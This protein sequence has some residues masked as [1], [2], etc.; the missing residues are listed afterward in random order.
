MAYPDNKEMPVEIVTVKDEPEAHRMFINKNKFGKKNLTADELFCHEYWGNE[1]QGVETEKD[2]NS[3]FLS[4]DLGT[5]E[6]GT[7]V[8]SKEGFNVDHGVTVA[9]P[10]FRKAIKKSSMPAVARAS[11]DLQ[12]VF[13]N[14]RNLRSELLE[15]ISLIYSNQDIL[16]SPKAVQLVK[17][18]LDHLKVS[19]H[20]VQLNVST[21]IK[22]AAGAKVNKNDY[23]VALGF[24]MSLATHVKSLKDPELTALHKK[25]FVP[26]ARKLKRIIK[27]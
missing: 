8:G 16:S 6:P 22:T 9:I 10:G 19:H 7:V 27:G 15:G 12:S 17:E 3:C 5:N 20:G 21:A 1:T 4:V 13:V 26:H 2:L 14:D 25:L 23:C 11:I 18:H 24:L